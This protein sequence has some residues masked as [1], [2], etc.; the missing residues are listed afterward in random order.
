MAQTSVSNVFGKMKD[1]SDCELKVKREMMR[2][3]SK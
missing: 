1:R 2:I 3:H